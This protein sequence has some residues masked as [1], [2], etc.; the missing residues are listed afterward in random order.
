MTRLLTIHA[1]IGATIG[2]TIGVGGCTQ[3]GDL[4]H[5]AR[6]GSGEGSG[7]HALPD[8]PAPFLIGGDITYRNLLYDLGARFSDAVGQEREVVATLAQHG[9]G[10]VRIRQYH[11]PGTPTVFTNGETYRLQPGYQDLADG[12][13]AAHIAAAQGLSV[14]VSLH[15]SDLWTNREQQA[16]PAAWAELPSFEAQAQALYDHTFD[17]VSTYSAE[18]IPLRFVA[19][20]SAIN[21]QLAGFPSSGPE[22]VTLL[23]Q[24]ARAVRDASPQTEIVLHI[25]ADLDRSTVAAWL[26]RI[27]DAAIDYD[28]L[29]LSLF[30]FWTGWTLAEMRDFVEWTADI[31]GKPIMICEF[32]ALWTGTSQGP[33]PPMGGEDYPLST[34]GQH[35]YV[36]AYVDTMRASGV[37]VAAVYW[38]PIWID[39]P[40]AGWV[41]G[42]GN[43]EWD[44]ALFDA[45]GLPLPALGAFS[46][47]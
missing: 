37:V 47:S 34:M 24:G 39:W 10:L 42:Q 17:T 18:G 3:V 26:E 44:S 15:Y 12:V 4:G 40:G 5:S 1:T 13:R 31:S 45:Q 30:P 16:M 35:D 46:P 32:G 6:G 9:F 23:A 21:D 11:Q 29:G 27:H 28:V 41:V 38:D 19:L 22:Y 8:V 14:F 7:T 33:Y 25:G 20:G 43:S 36:Q 2:I